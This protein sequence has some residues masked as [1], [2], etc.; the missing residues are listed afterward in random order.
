MINCCKSKTNSFA[1]DMV[2]CAEKH[3]RALRNSCSGRLSKASADLTPKCTFIR[4]GAAVLPPKS[5]KMSILPAG[6]KLSPWSTVSLRSY[7]TAFGVDIMVFLWTSCHVSCPGTEPW[8]L[9][10]LI[11]RSSD[12]SDSRRLQ[13]PVRHRRQPGVCPGERWRS[14]SPRRGCSFQKRQSSQTTHCLLLWD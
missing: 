7:N 10:K 9:A 3:F 12:E 6:V 13:Q 8:R 1:L 2:I 14:C 4:Q 11:R 5:A